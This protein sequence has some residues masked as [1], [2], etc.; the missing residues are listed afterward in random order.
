[1]EH[2]F[3]A[4]K[5]MSF[6]NYIFYFFMLNIFFL[7]SNIPFL[8]FFFLVGISHI[9]EYLPYVTVSL[10]PLAPSLCALIH[11][12]V[13]LIE[14]KDIYPFKEY[15]KGYCKNFVQAFIVGAIELAF[16]FML[17][18]NISFFKSQPNLS[19]FSI[20]FMILFAII[21]LMT[22]FLYLFISKYKMT[23]I[24]IFKAAITVTI[25]KPLYSIANAV[26]FLFMLVLFEI[27]AGTTFLFIGSGYAFLLV[28]SNKKLFMQLEETEKK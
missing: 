13:K 26:I 18:I 3:D 19:I 8:L 11:C 28:V 16:I 10:L 6:F 7:A 1:M 25:G 9:G 14:N 17:N 15:K 24:D 2:I 22:P 20:I 12:M 27:V 21:L 4:E 5:I 23:T